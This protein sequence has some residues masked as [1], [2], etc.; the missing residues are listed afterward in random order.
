MGRNNRYREFDQEKARMRLR[1][2]DTN[3]DKSCFGYA[4]YVHPGDANSS[5]W[6][7]AIV[8]RQTENTSGEGKRFKATFLHVTDDGIRGAADDL[9]EGSVLLAPAVPRILGSSAVEHQELLTRVHQ[10]YEE[11]GMTEN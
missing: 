3:N 1:V 11:E 2:Q 6:R 4:R 10:L 8:E 9:D 5:E 7:Q